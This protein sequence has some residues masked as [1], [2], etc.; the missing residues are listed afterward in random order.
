MFNFRL[1]FEKMSCFKGDRGK[2]ALVAF[3]T[4]VLVQL[5]LVIGLLVLGTKGKDEIGTE[6]GNGVPYYVGAIVVGSVFLVPVLQIIAIIILSSLDEEYCIT[7]CL[8]V[9][10]CLCSFFGILA[11]VLGMIFVIAFGIANCKKESTD[12][13]DSGFCSYDT[14]I[15]A[16]YT[17]AVVALVLILIM[18]MSTCFSFYLYSKYSDDLVSRNDS[19]N[20]RPSNVAPFNYNR[21]PSQGP[22]LNLSTQ[23]QQHLQ[24]QP[25]TIQAGP[26]PPRYHGPTAPPLYSTQNEGYSDPAY[27]PISGT[28]DSPPSYETVM[29]SAGTHQDSAS[30]QPQTSSYSTS[31]TT[32]Q[33]NYTRDTQRRMVQDRERRLDL[34]RQRRMGVP[35]NRLIPKYF[36]RPKR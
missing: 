6:T 12:Y 34:D 21:G 20:A 22:N 19:A 26:G 13:T 16:N 14:N 1:L 4:L 18:L 10:S 24:T 30:N 9:G 27:P 7:D 28:Q 23:R 3:I 5:G 31:S 25:Y 35:Q 29:H 36:A 32:E 15:D 11:C 2:K 8:V 17:I 33:I